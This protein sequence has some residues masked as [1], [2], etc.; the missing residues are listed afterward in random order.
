[1]ALK[2]SYYEFAKSYLAIFVRNLTDRKKPILYLEGTWKHRIFSKTFPAFSSFQLVFFL[3][4]GKTLEIPIKVTA[5]SDVL[6]LQE[7]AKIFVHPAYFFKK[8]Q[9]QQNFMDIV[10]SDVALIKLKNKI[11][12]ANI[13]Q[14]PTK[15]AYDAPFCRTAGWGSKS[16]HT[17]VNIQENVLQMLHFKLLQKDECSK[18]LTDAMVNLVANNEELHHQIL[19]KICVQNYY[20]KTKVSTGDSG[21]PLM[22]NGE[23]H[24]V[25]NLVIQEKNQDNEEIYTNIFTEITYY[26]DWIDSIFKEEGEKGLPDHILRSKSFLKKSCVFFTLTLTTINILNSFQ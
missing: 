20:G 23:L 7:I 1:M 2:L 22:C 9:N 19:N 21:C 8:V 13:A 26:T 4:L 12:D 25:T 15:S 11:I 18:L 3:F 5:V 24:G 6:Q 14:L 10:S 16:N 17:N